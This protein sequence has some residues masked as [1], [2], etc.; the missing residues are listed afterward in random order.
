MF[1]FQ[2]VAFSLQFSNRF[3]LLANLGMETDFR[4]RGHQPGDDEPDE[5]G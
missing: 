4:E 5:G 3:L 2:S 1:S